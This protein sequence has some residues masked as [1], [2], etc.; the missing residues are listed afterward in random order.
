MNLH[1]GFVK[2]VWLWRGQCGF[3]DLVPSMHGR[4]L[5]TPR[6]NACEANVQWAT[7]QLLRYARSC[8]VDRFEGVV[9]PDLALLAYLQHHGAATPL[10]DVSVDPLV[11][12]WMAVNPGTLAPPNRSGEGYVFAIAAPGKELRLGAMDSRPYWDPDAGSASV[13]GQ[14]GPKLFWYQAPDISPRLRAQRG[15]FVIGSFQP[16]PTAKRPT[17]V[18][19]GLVQATPTSA[20]LAG[21]WTA[22]M[23]QIARTARP[24]GHPRKPG[25]MVRFRIPAA[26]FARVNEWLEQRIGLTRASVYPVPWHSPLIEEFAQCFG[27]SRVIDWP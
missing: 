3:G 25:T 13:A 14:L 23:T 21:R 24:Q 20:S 6:L 16:A 9:L 22:M 4:V 2:D 10:M 17:T 5:G 18:I 7:R 15:S 26:Y 12:I 27:R 8:Q 11:A 1:T 19:S